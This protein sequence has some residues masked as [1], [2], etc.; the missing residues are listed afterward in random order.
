M[1]PNGIESTYEDDLEEHLLVDLHELLIPLLNIGGLLAGV[2]V[3]LVDNL[4]VV[5]V[6]FAPFKDFVKN[7]LVDL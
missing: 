6:V 7:R 4:W 3:I 5:D 2:G 1:H